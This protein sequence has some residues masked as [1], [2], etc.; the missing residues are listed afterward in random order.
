MK[1]FLAILLSL[2][3]LTSLF[4]GLNVSALSSE[5]Y[6]V[7]LISEGVVE[8][9]SPENYTAYQCQSAVD[10]GATPEGV[11]RIGDGT[12]TGYTDYTKGFRYHA[13]G[14]E[15]AHNLSFTMPEGCNTISGVAG[16]CY[17]VPGPDAGSAV[18]Y[19]EA[20]YVAITVNSEPVY[21]SGD[22]KVKTGY[23]FKVRAKAGSNIIIS[24]LNTAG[25]S[26]HCH[27]IF[28][29]PVLTH[30][31]YPDVEMSFDSDVYHE[32]DTITP[33]LTGTDI[34][35]CHLKWELSGEVL[36]DVTDSYTIRP[37]D[38]GKTLKV[39]VLDDEDIVITS[40]ERY[41]S[42]LTTVSIKTETGED[43]TSKEDYIDA[44]FK[45]QG[46]EEFD[47][48]V[49]YDGITEIRGRGN[50][51]W[52]FPKKSYKLKL[53]K[54]TNL[55]GMGKNKHWTLI[56]CYW[57]E[58]FLRNKMSYDLSGIMGLNYASSVWVDVYLNGNYHGV[59]LLCEHIRVDDTRVDIYDW[60]GTAEDV[61]EA[62]YD[63]N[64]DK[65]SDDGDFAD[66]MNE[67]MGWIT[68]GE[69]TFEGNTY[70]VSDYY[71]DEIPDIN[72][73]YLLEMD[74]HRDEVSS[75]QTISGLN[76]NI[77]NP[78]FC[79]TN[80]EMLNFVKTYMQAV[81]DACI[82][83]DF[84]TT[85]KGVQMRYTDLCDLDSMVKWWMVNELFFNWDA[86]YNSNFMYM[87]IGTKLYFGPVWDMDITAAGYGT[88]DRYD[89]WQTWFYKR[90]ACMNLWFKEAVS[91]P[92]FLSYAHEIYWQ[93][94]DEF[95]QLIADGGYMEQSHEKLAASGA[96][97]TKLWRWRKGYEHDYQLMKEWMKNRLEWL[98]TQ[99]ATEESLIR[100]MAAQTSS[101]GVTPYSTIEAYA[102]SSLMQANLSTVS[103][104]ML[105]KDNSKA[106]AKYLL[107]TPDTLKNQI[108]VTDS[109][110][111][112]IKRELNGGKGVIATVTNGIAEFPDLPHTAFV[113]GGQKSVILYTGYR[114]DGTVA[115]K[116]YA[117]INTAKCTHVGTGYYIENTVIPTCSK[118]G[119][120]GDEVCG[121]CGEIAVK[122]Q[123]VPKVSHSYAAATC[124]APKTCKVCKAT[125]GKAL[126]H[127]Y[128]TTVTKATT[129]AN[130]KIVTKCTRCGKTSSSSTIYKIKSFKLSTTSYSYSGKSKKPTVTIK[131]SK[132]NKISTKY[133]TVKYTNNKNIG[134]ATAK[135]TFKGNYSGTKSLTFK[136]NPKKV[137]SLKLKSS[138]KKQLTVSFKKDTKVSGYEIVYA[139]NSKFTKG[140]QTVKIS[141]YKTYKKTIKSLKSKKTYYLKVRAYKTVKG[142]KYYGSYC[143]YK[144]LKIK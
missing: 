58:N 42:P 141:S 9:S 39:T 62:I 2:T 116:L 1:R 115:G 10:K 63:A 99:F 51:S 123:A 13:S 90:S 80:P 137:S 43:V 126:G 3:L 118:M 144:K 61:A 77:K 106:A 23:P 31:D 75:V 35:K 66:Y 74:T 72:G 131:D 67:N 105:I 109:E 38:L 45:V 107:Q 88:S 37:E 16:V 142:K 86:G 87:D 28:G 25:D 57:D 54:K 17:H 120:S 135:L 19:K 79:I 132:G 21:N 111:T 52:G 134:T 143:S 95:Q 78:E 96:Q 70:K 48:E 76:I 69:V 4:S 55:C 15:T 121:L 7:D 110:I 29:D 83:K 53:D 33:T 60:E 47:N 138:K 84:T 93:Y 89:Q 133:Y 117:T 102:D 98:D 34:D 8:I 5:K 100:S 59:Y 44:E 85:Y 101:D 139:T 92:V 108:K 24:V 49:Q 6:L 11:V 18:Y 140:K 112:T 130:G 129:K 125:T 81:E 113:N 71:T 32:G 136:I 20:C 127:S 91:D 73:G 56:A 22:M 46:D 114:A 65:I 103:G 12:D 27:V 41:L 50:T 26:S 30:E 64:S 122:G 94:R 119:Y 36:S 97:N 82:S 14:G 40:K 128:K 68:S 104:S 124:T